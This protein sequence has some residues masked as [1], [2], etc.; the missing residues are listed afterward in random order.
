MTLQRQPTE[1]GGD[2]DRL[3][4]EY[5]RLLCDD[6]RPASCR[7]GAVKSRESRGVD[8]WTAIGL[9]AASRM[10]RGSRE[11]ASNWFCE[12]ADSEDPIIA[13]TWP[14]SNVE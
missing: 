9:D 2:S 11:R 12:F 1:T 3:H 13:V 7:A 10:R 6:G 4:V 14:R 8:G 5:R